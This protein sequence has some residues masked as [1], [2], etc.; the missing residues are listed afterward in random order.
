[1]IR[2]V[3]NKLNKSEFYKWAVILSILLAAEIVATVAIPVWRQYF[4]DGIEAKSYE[5]FYS[6]VLYF[7]L[8]MAVFV[9]TQGFKRYVSQRISLMMRT[10][11]TKVLQK[12][13][14]RNLES[15]REID[16]PDQRI[17]EDA[18]LVTDLSMQV[19]VESLISL[20]IIIGLLFQIENTALLIMSTLYTC[21]ALTIA[22]IFKKPMVNTEIE[23]Q[24]READ[25]R[26]SLAKIVMGEGDFTSKDKYLAVCQAYLTYIKVYMYYALFHSTKSYLTSIIPLIILVP[27]YFAG[28][29]SFGDV[30]KGVSEF[31]LLTINATILL[32][33][34]PTIT[35]MIASYKR[36]INF[37]HLNTK[38]DL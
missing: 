16:N 31:E 5:V 33:L 37:Y 32:I 8:L 35:K 4:Y 23:L 36:I 14:V 7:F 13:W 29:G 38:G 11:I 27:A 9:V 15:H 1:M 28:Q 18:R 24:R 20:I 12:K 19:V 3:Y 30:M 6:G 21:A 2:E 17:N 25:H 26:F 10:A 22:W 34:Y